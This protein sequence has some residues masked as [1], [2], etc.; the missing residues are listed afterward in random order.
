MTENAV[1]INGKA[2]RYTSANGD[3]ADQD[4]DSYCFF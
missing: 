1:R 3:P 4:P 2:V